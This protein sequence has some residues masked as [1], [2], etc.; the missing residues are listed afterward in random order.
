M[1]EGGLPRQPM[2]TT[3]HPLAPHATTDTTH[4]PGVQYPRTTGRH[5]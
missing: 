2:P 3:H 4:H 5:A 1:G